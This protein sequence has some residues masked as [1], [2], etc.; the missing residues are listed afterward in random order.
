[1]GAIAR[2]ALKL[3]RS[4]SPIALAAK[5]ILNH[6]RN[7]TVPLL[8]RIVRRLVR[9][10]YFLHFGVI[11]AFR[12]LLIFYRGPL[13]Q[14]RCASFGRGVRLGGKLPFI[15][16]PVEI[17][18]GNN[19]GIGGNVAILSGYIFEKRPRLILEDRCDLGWGVFLVVNKE[20]VIEEDARISFDCR[21]SD[22]DGH[23]READLRDANLPPD[24]KDIRPVRI[25]RSAWIGNGTHIMKGVTIGEG[26]IIGANSVVI[27]DVPP[28]ALA[29]GNP[30]EVL[31]R[32]FGKPSTAKR[33]QTVTRVDDQPEAT[34]AAS[35]SSD[36]AL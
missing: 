24:P 14:S 18:V 13:F 9:P 33:T 17:D 22:S 34:G 31:I 30:A 26:A 32:G 8:P 1:L 20:I 36:Q 10:L 12:N 11:V 28:F 23:P 25:C 5:S 29:I 27:S 21:I 3:K 35:L 2:F 19:V 7:P 4:Q 15:A 16:G 6:L